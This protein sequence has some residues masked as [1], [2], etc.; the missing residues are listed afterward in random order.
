MRLKILRALNIQPIPVR[1]EPAADLRALRDLDR[2][3]AGLGLRGRRPD[4]GGGAGGRVGAVH[5][6]WQDALPT[7]IPHHRTGMLFNTPKSVSK[8]IM[9]IMLLPK[10]CQLL[11]ISFLNLTTLLI[12]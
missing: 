9:K 2:L 11:Y 12:L 4:D 1:V 7:D 3:A 10:L 8:S 5:G 6:A